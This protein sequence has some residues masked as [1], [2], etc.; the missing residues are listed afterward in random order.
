MEPASRAGRNAVMYVGRLLSR[1]CMIRSVVF[2]VKG[3]TLNLASRQVLIPKSP[4]L[5]KGP[6]TEDSY[7]ASE[8]HSGRAPCV[9]REQYMHAG[10]FHISTATLWCVDT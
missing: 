10:S 2:W 4:E 7:S 8:V 1:Q 5:P 9:M 3:L 6:G